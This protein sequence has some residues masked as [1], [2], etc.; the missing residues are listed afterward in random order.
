MRLLLTRGIAESD[1]T[2]AMLEAAG[3]H[4]VVSPVISFVAV[5]SAWPDEPARGILATSARAFL[6]LTVETA[7]ARRALPL[8]LVGRHTEAA[9]RASGFTGPA[10]VAPDA[11]RLL[12]T[13]PANPDQPL[14][15]LAGRDRKADLEDGLAARNR[16]LL[17]VETYRAEA[18]RS[19]TSEALAA[20]EADAI[21]GVLHF[22]R[23]SASIFLALGVGHDV[24][25]IRHFCLSADVALPLRAAG[26]ASHVAPM[27][28]AQALVDMLRDFRDT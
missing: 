12:T 27:P 3:H 8:Y 24:G 4:V 18:A 25:R 16:R 11:A 20:L 9:A 1:R 14:V 21:D 22:S 2:R 5:E 23:R 19:L 15:Y 6:G 26:C 17:V 7:E 10:L 28:E 13:M